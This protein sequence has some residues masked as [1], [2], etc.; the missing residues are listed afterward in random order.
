MKLISPEGFPIGSLETNSYKD[1]TEQCPQGAQFLM[2]SQSHW[3]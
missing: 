1:V 2:L 3:I